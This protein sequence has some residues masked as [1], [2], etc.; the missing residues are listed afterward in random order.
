[1]SCH[2]HTAFPGPGTALPTARG[3]SF[4]WL[5]F[6]DGVPPAAERLA[7]MGRLYGGKPPEIAKDDD[8]A[9]AK[10]DATAKKTTQRGN[11]PH[12]PTGD[13]MPC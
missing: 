13:R 10:D 4:E 1:M 12:K 3:I 11:D 2:R 7:E 6:P 8:D 5:A 9:K